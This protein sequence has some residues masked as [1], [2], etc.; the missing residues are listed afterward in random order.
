MLQEIRPE[1]LTESMLATQ[2]IGIHHAALSCLQRTALQARSLEDLDAA[3]RVTT[4]F[5]RLYMEQLDAMAKLKGKTGQQKITVEHVDVH[6]GGQA[7]VGLVSA[8][9]C[10]G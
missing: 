9:C 4:R 3:S 7:I 8:S 10:G 1:S 6:A 5:M 2:M